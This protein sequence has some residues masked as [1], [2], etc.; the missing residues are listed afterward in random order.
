VVRR[1][2]QPVLAVLGAESE[3]LWPRFGET[4]RLLLDWLPH[5]EGFVLPGA[6]HA[7]QLQNPRGLAEALA[8]FWAHHPLSL[9]E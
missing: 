1:L 5:A 3:A 4:H 2:P 6:T 7:M 8:A 9:T